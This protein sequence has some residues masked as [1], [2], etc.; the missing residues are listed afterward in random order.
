MRK[1]GVKGKIDQTTVFHFIRILAEISSQAGRNGLVVV[2][3]EVET[4]SWMRKDQREQGL[5]NVRQ[6][7]DA[8]SEGRLPRCYFVFTG[9]AGFF[10]DR[11]GVPALQPLNDRIKLEDPDELY[12]N[13]NHPQ[14][15]LKSFDYEKLI[16][17]GARV[18]EIYEVAY[19]PLDRSRASDALIESLAD[20]LT[21]RFGGRVDVVPRQFLRQLVDTFDR[22]LEYPDYEPISRLD[23]EVSEYL[24]SDNLSP[25]EEE[26]VTF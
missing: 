12:P 3:D 26:S 6:I 9:T 7:V 17:V 22:I 25:V 1:V 20:S 16:E 24:S 18:R 8:A 5:Q 4:I 10:D 15:V 23:E 11:H 21:A 19:R 14:I 13:Y 2:L